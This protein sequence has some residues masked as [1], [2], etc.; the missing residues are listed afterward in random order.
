MVDLH[1]SSGAMVVDKAPDGP[2]SH[3]GCVRCR[4][5]RHL[6]ALAR[7]LLTSP[8]GDR[9]QGRLQVSYRQGVGTMHKG[10]R[11]LGALVVARVA[12]FAGVALAASL[13]LPLET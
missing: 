6:G 11:R 5:D 9:I 13:M 10:A 2:E 4:A 3:T 12:A 1:Q 8:E 7:D